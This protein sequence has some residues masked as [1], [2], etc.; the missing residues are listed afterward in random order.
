MSGVDLD[1]SRIRKGAGDAIL[2]W[3]TETGGQA[4]AQLRETLDRI[5]GEGGTPLA[6]AATSRCSGSFTSRT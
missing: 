3:V 5:A 6:V 2:N 1:G 4:P